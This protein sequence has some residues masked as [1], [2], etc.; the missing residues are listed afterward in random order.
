MSAE[1]ETLSGELAALSAVLDGYGADLARWPAAERV[2]FATLL[3]TNPAAGRLRAEAQAF[4]R[5]L[6]LAP[7]VDPQSKAKADALADRIMAAAAAAGPERRGSAIRTEVSNLR[8]R[9]AA[10]TPLGS[11]S[12]LPRS[13]TAAPSRSAWPALALLAASLLVGIVG[14][15]SGVMDRFG[16]PW[17]ANG[18]AAADDG[19]GDEMAIA[20]NGDESDGDG[21]GLW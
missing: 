2:R 9:S 12:T 1:N 10:V 16:A 14:G 18:L 21:E 6:S 4:E 19:S 5:L 20:L 13:M 11:G 7:E 8:A 3:A 15:A 17:P